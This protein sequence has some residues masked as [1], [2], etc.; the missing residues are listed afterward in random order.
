MLRENK[1][2]VQETKRAMNGFSHLLLVPQVQKNI[3]AAE[4]ARQLFL[5]LLEDDP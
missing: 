2:P 5:Y 1:A 3:D 4:L